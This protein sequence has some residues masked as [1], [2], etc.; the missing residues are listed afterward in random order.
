MDLKA[1]LSIMKCSNDDHTCKGICLGFLPVHDLGC[2][3]DV[4][5]TERGCPGNEWFICC[6]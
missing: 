5:T 1:N 4:M 3:D 6:I 2:I